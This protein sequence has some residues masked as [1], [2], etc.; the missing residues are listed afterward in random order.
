MSIGQ[1]TQGYNQNGVFFGFTLSNQPPVTHVLS[2][3]STTGVSVAP[4]TGT[5]YFYSTSINQSNYY[6]GQA[7]QFISGSSRMYGVINYLNGLYSNHIGANITAIG[8]S[9]SYTT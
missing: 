4:S 7:V 9:T 8:G 1:S 6:I 3:G 5:K 2:P